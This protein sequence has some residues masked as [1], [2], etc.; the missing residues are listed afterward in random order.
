MCGPMGITFWLS[1]PPKSSSKLCDAKKS[2][3][4]VLGTTLLG[5]LLAVL[6][7]IKMRYICKVSQDIRLVTHCIRRVER[8]CF[9]GTAFEIK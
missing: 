3:V 9:A 8:P 5:S 7:S 1:K 6:L 4:E 2:H